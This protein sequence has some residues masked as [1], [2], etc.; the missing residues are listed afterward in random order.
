MASCSRS[1][2]KSFIK[3]QKKK[4][5]DVGERVVAVYLGNFDV[6]SFFCLSIYGKV[7]IVSWTE[8]RGGNI[9][10]LTR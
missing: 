9:L 10:K 6:I 3:M 4:D 8:V 5:A 7:L 1:P 2:S